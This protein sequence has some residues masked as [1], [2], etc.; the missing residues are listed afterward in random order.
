M[1]LSWPMRLSIL[2]EELT[3]AFSH[4]HRLHPE[5]FAKNSEVDG[6]LSSQLDGEHL[7]LGIGDYGHIFRVRSTKERKELGN[8]LIVGR[9]RCGKG[10]LANSQILTWPQSIIVNDI[11][12]DLYQ[13]TAWYRSKVSQIRVFGPPGYG[14][15]F[16]PFRGMVTED[17][18]REAATNLL[19]RPDEGENS[20]FTERAI[21]MLTQLFVAARLEEQSLL[22]YAR[23]MIYSGPIDTAKRLNAISVRH[24]RY[25]NLATRFLDMRLLD[26]L[27]KSFRDDFFTSCWSTLTHRMSPLLTD[28]I[29]SSISESDFTAADIIGGDKPV[30][31]YLRWPEHSLL[32]LAPLVRL[33]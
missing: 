33:V 12:G 30:T 11:K 7:L 31:L 23:H 5:R 26:M 32:S 16:N 22:P 17:Q 8:M 9:T 18:L 14:D 13:Q 28:A 24:N 4:K 1:S 3:E 29:V 27:K 25:P 20:I 21:T 2:Y 19:F 10:L 6:I 15:R